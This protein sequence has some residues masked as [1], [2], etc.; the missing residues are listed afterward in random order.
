MKR[1]IIILALSFVTA[2]ASGQSMYDAIAYGENNYYGTARSMALGNA[3]TAVGGDLGSVALNPAGAAVSNYLQFVIT[4]G[5]SISSTSSSYASEYGASQYQG[6]YNTNKARFMMPNLGLNVHFYLPGTFFKSMSFALVCNS[7]QQHLFFAEAA[8]SNSATAM[9]GA[10][11]YSANY[12]A[13]GSGHMMEPDVFKNYGNEG[14]YTNTN[15]GWNE[16]CAYQSNMI[17]Y[18]SKNKG[19]WGVAEALDGSILGPLRQTSQRQRVGTKNDL[20]ANFAFNHDDSF[21]LGISLGIPFQRYSYSEIFR[22]A[23]EDN[24]RFPITFNT[25]KGPITTCYTGS[26][27]DYAYS[28]KIDGI[29]GKVGFIWLPVK[30]LRVGAS[31]QSPTSMTISE[32]YR[33]SISSTFEDSRL[34]SSGTSP[35]GEFHYRM[36]SPYRASFGVATTFGTAGLLSLDYELTDFSIMRYREMRYNGN[37]MNGSFAVVNNV[38]KNFC[39]RSHY[40]RAG[41]E[42]KLGPCF[43]VR[44]GYTF[45][46]SPECHYMN[47][48]GNVVYAS[49]FE[50]DF[51]RYMN[52]ELTLS[53]RAYDFSQAVHT[54]SVGF[55]FASTGSFFADAVVRFNKYP[56]SSF[57]PYAKY[58]YANAPDVKVRNNLFDAAIT[59]GWRF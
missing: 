59:F 17:S 54:A 51:D 3:M 1:L 58:S 7:T 21:Y 22:E 33:T 48:L 38:M 55:G 43:A 11:A 30:G 27:Y 36:T 53:G 56:D 9:S 5:V 12:N 42:L 47:N 29:Y 50:A 57:A 6:P 49:D 39:G 35:L 16:L 34:S 4:P 24:Q 25:E 19:Y 15:Y 32:T 8:G 20:V 37:L 46:T 28:A 40:L 26:L 45:R 14:A 52:R 31:F 13:D 44:L 2:L 10:F 41:A 23:P 18:D